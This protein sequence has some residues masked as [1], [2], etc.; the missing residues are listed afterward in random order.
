[1]E[2]GMRILVTG[3]AGFIGGHLVESLLKQ[4]HTVRVV[5]NLSTGNL[6]NLI[7]VRGQIEFI[8]GDVSDIQTAMQ[9]AE[10]MDAISHQAAVPSVPRSVNN[11]QEAHQACATT[12]LNMLCAAKEHQVK[13]FVYAASS[14][15]YGDNPE[16]PKQECM[17][18]EPRSPY[19]AAK[20]AGEHYLEAFHACYGLDGIALRYFNI[21]GPRQDPSSPYSG[22][23]ARFISLMSQGIRPT[24]FGDGSQS[25]DF[26]Y[27]A[28]AVHAN[29]LALTS[30]DRLPGCA[31][32][33]GT[34]ARISLNLLVRELNQLL[35]AAL[36]PIYDSP[37]AGDVQHSLASIAKAQAVLGYKP[38]VEFDTGLALTLAA[39]E[40]VPCP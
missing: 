29:V 15:A 37:R 6:D 2:D 31:V 39:K 16:Q 35:G 4:G 17:R 21:F 40:L 32:N 12:T 25:R 27:V 3:G 38:V 14:S 36:E 24:I 19:A 23:I 33:I 26:T 5:D 30:S 9:V 8:L 1:M 28:N 13:R 7:A 10:G 18:P 11:P 34:G 20:L 22:V